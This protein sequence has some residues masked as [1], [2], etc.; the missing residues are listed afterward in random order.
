MVTAAGC[1][2]VRRVVSRFPSK[3]PGTKAAYLAAFATF[4]GFGVLN[5][6]LVDLFNFGSLRCTAIEDVLR[7][8]MFSFRSGR[9]WL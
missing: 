5:F 7:N 3:A 4:A 1:G 6:Q 9:A 2:Q 8:S